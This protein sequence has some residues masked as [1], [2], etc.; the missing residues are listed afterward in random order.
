MYCKL[1][2]KR[3]MPNWI[4]SVVVTARQGDETLIM[5]DAR[6]APCASRVFERIVVECLPW[7]LQEKSAMAMLLEAASQD[8]EVY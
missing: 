1:K 2:R 4:R 8:K 5:L 7:D 6:P 3:F